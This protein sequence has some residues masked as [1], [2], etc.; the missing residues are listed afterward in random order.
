MVSS[1]QAPSAE[2]FF[3]CQNVTSTRFDNVWSLWVPRDD[4]TMQLWKNEDIY[5]A[6]EDLQDIL[7]LTEKAKSNIVY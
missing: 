6:K 1:E 7:L 2:T 4:W 5:N 3:S